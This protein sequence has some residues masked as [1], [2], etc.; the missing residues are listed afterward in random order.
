[1]NNQENNWLFTSRDQRSSA[2][3]EGEAVVV[4]REP[5][6]TKLMH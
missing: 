3:S 5:S 6:A 2:A 4:H 1:M